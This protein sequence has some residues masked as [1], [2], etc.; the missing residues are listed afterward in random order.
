MARTLK[1]F[2][3][4]DRTLHQLQQ[5]VKLGH[6]T[7]ETAAVTEAINLLYYHRVEQANEI[8]LAHRKIA[9]TPANPDLH[10]RDGKLWLNLGLGVLADGAAAMLAEQFPGEIETERTPAGEWLFYHPQASQDAYALMRVII[11]FKFA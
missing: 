1:P 8:T 9:E 6:C 10:E 5:L 7:N 3:L 2:R 4:P 11:M